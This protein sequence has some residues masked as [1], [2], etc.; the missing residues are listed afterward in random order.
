MT[1]IDIILE[2]GAIATGTTVDEVRRGGRSTRRMFA[3][4]AF[5]AGKMCA[6]GYS[7]PEIGRALCRHHTT[8]LNL[9]G[10]LRGARKARRR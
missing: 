10:R 4:R 8:I 5:I 3:R 1:P 7:Y 6:E 9:L 2:A